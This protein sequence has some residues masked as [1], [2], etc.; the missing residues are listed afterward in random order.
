MVHNTEES[1]KVDTPIIDNLTSHLQLKGNGSSRQAHYNKGG[2]RQEGCTNRKTGKTKESDRVAVLD[3][4]ILVMARQLLGVSQA[5][6]MLKSVLIINMEVNTESFAVRTAKEATEQWDTSRKRMLDAGKT[7]EQ[8]KTTLGPPNVYV[9]LR[10]V[11]EMLE[12][13]D[14]GE[15][16][17]EIQKG[18]QV[19]G[20]KWE[21]IHYYYPIVKV[22]KCRK[23]DIK[24]IEISAPAR[25]L[26][27][28]PNSPTR[29]TVLAALDGILPWLAT[30]KG[31]KVLRGIAP[32]GEMERIIQ[33]Y[34]DEANK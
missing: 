2:T 18:F 34:I 24:R 14:D 25:E 5:S 4:I 26:L 21:T 19:E 33:T 6:R 32:P 11:K 20:I 9:T 28:I 17:T 27:K 10:W 8:V 12:A 3:K 29:N 13:M 30:M 1:T 15:L 23:S 22:C 7:N 16:K 31:H